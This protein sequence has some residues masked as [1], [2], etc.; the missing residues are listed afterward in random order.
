MEIYRLKMINI[1][2]T[3]LKMLKKK[4]VIKTKKEIDNYNTQDDEIRNFLQVLK[5]CWCENI[6]VLH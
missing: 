4:A 2:L 6:P 5:E 3:M 1:Y